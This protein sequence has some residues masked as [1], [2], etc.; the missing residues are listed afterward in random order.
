MRKSICLALL[1]LA[2]ASVTRAQTLVDIATNATDPSNLADS[3]PSIAVNP[4][5]T[6]QISVVTFS[7]GWS[8]TTGRRGPV[9]MSTDGGATWAKNFVLTAPT[10]A[11]TGPGDQ[12]IVFSDAGTFFLVELGLGVAVPR[13]F[14]YRPGGANWIAGAAYGD[15]QPMIESTAA[16]RLSPWL[17]FGLAP[18]RSMSERTTDDGVTVAQTIIGSNALPNRTTRIAVG[19]NGN[20]FVIYKTRQGAVG[21]SFETATF[22]VARSTDAGVTWNTPGVAVHPG[23]VTT[24]FTSSWGDAKNGGKVARAR[25]SDAWIAANPAVNSVWAVFCNRDASGLGQIFATRSTDGG[26]TWSAP[27]RVSDGTRNSAYPEVAVAANGAVGVMYID[28][29]ASGAQT[30]YTHRF[31]RSFD[32][33]ANWNRVALQSLRTQELSNGVNS[34]LWGDYEGLAASGNKFVGVFTG[35]SIGRANVQFDPIFFRMSGSP[36]SISPVAGTQSTVTVDTGRPYSWM[37]GSDGNLWVNWWSG[38]AWGWSNQGVPSGVQIKDGVGVTVVDG[39]RPYAF[40]LGNDNNLWVNWW[41]GSAWAWA[42]QGRPSGTVGIASRVGAITVD[43]GR[44]YAFVQG[45]D[46]NL[47]VNWWSGS[48]WGWALLSRPAGVDLLTPMGT[49]TVDGGR[50]YVFMKGSDGNL[51]VQWWSGSAWSWSNLSK[52]AGVTLASSVG[53]VAVS[54]HRPYVFVQGSDGNLWLRWWSGSTW[55]WANQGHPP[56]GVTVSSGIGVTDVDHGRPYAFVKGSDG[57]VWVN[58]WSGTAWAW[59]NQG[60]PSGVSITDPAGVITVDGSR[61]YAWSKGSDGNLWVNWWSGTAWAWA[62]QGTPP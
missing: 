20:A 36:T 3:E 53:A 51:W 11:S 10:A 57:N 19:Q 6:N 48:A 12:K 16:T 17:N 8:A 46:G 4:R 21:T 29:D 40:I 9:W 58:W 26:L 32:N 34:F 30:V 59:A 28:F 45:S 56:G 24:W 35:R 25:S 5:N 52:P 23:T 41:S 7:E 15:D 43:T 42:N 54:G 50:P 14:F 55:A 18:E 31:A 62:N 27:V 38:S 49:I 37:R 33:G 22:R 61:P 60:R 47:W 1:I 2:I 44:P 39:G 13:C